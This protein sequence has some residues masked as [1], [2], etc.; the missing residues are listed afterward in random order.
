M[1]NLRTLAFI[2]LAVLTVW[3]LLAAD[4]PVTPTGERA[5]LVLDEAAGSA[6]AATEPAESKVAVE[7]NS[8]T[9]A[10]LKASVFAAGGSCSSTTTCGRPYNPTWNAY[11]NN[12]CINAGH[13][14][15]FCGRNGRSA[16]CIC[17]TDQPH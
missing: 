12:F 8:F 11:C 16:C 14:A 4:E 10:E 9:A 13:A 7:E 6:T 15:G 1:K 5:P 3:P 2:L 17:A